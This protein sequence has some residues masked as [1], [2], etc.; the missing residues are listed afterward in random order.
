MKKILCIGGAGQLG[1]KVVSILK[2]YHVTN[3]DFKSHQDAKLNIELQKDVTPA[4]SN[5][6]VLQQF[7]KNNVKFDSII[8]TAGGWVGGNIKDD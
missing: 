8:V 6:Y 5:N 1:S 3:L 2:N 4:E 7:Q